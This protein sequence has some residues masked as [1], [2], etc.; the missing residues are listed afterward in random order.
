M[1]RCPGPRIVPEL[2][3]GSADR[4]APSCLVFVR[5][6]GLVIRSTHQLMPCEKWRRAFLRVVHPANRNAAMMVLRMIAMA[7]G[8]VPARRVDLSSLKVVSRTFSAG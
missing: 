5:L 1:G 2:S 6:T 7:C 4:T 3:A 8:A